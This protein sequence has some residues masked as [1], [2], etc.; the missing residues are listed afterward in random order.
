MAQKDRE[1]LGLVKVTTPALTIGGLTA[2]GVNSALQQIIAKG[3]GVDPEYIATMEARPAIGLGTRHIATVL[4]SAGIAGVECTTLDAYFQ[5][6]VAYGTRANTNCQKVTF[7][8][9]FLLPR[10]IQASQGAPASI[11]LDALAISTDGASPVTIVNNATVPAGEAVSTAWTMGPISI[12]STSYD[13]EAGELDFG[14]GEELETDEGNAFPELAKIMTRN[15]VFRFA[16]RTAFTLYDLGIT[17]EELTAFTWYLR[18]LDSYGLRVADGTAE[19]IK[20]TTVGYVHVEDV[21][22][23]NNTQALTNVIVRC[24]NPG[25][26]ILT[27]DETSAI[28]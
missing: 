21:S 26:T 16:S 4:A 1:I 17:G 22:G 18:K 24:C 13:L 27:I 11:N 28:T 23:D 10:S 5:K 15:P 9:A 25:A 19:H 7:A 20:F 12:N 2:L 6:L 8:K 14:I 3:G